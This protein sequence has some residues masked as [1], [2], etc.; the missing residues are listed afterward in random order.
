M[1]EKDKLLHQRFP[2]ELWRRIATF[3]ENLRDLPCWVDK[4]LSRT[5]FGAKQNRGAWRTIF[6]TGK[7]PAD[8]RVLAEPLDLKKMI[9]AS[10]SHGSQK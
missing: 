2:E 7:S 8:V 10:A 3:L 1:V 9:G 4:G 6:E 5:L